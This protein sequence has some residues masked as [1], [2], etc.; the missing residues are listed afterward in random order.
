MAENKESVEN[1]E[2]SSSSSEWKICSDKLFATS[3]SS[4][5]T[6]LEKTINDYF[7]VLLIQV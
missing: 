6:K 2:I 5:E 1:Q 3:F 7:N 4:S